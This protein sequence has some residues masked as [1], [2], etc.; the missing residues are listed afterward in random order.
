ME[1]SAENEKNELICARAVERLR[2]HASI[3]ML[4][5]LIESVKLAFI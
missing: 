4:H 3:M 5:K 1:I 2:T